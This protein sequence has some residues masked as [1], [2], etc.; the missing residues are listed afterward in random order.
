MKVAILTMFNGL[1]KTYSLANIVE[2]QL[3][4]L[5]NDNIEVKM[6]VTENFNDNDKYG[7]FLDERIEWVKIINSIDGKQFIWYDYS[8]PDSKLHDSF[9]KEAELISKDFEKAL[10]DVSVCIM[11]DILYQGWHYI[12]NVAIRKAQKNLVEVKFLA[13]AHSYPVNRPINPLPHMSCRYTPM[14]NTIFV[15]PSYS[16]L[17]ALAKQYDVPEGLCRVVYNSISPFENMTSATKKLHREVNL[18]DTDILIIYPARLTTGKKLENISALAGAITSVA[19][20]TVKIVYCDFRSADIDPEEYKSAIRFVGEGYGIDSE[21]IIFTSEHGF[22][23]GFPHESVMEL[24]SLSNLYVCPSMSE[25]FGLTVIEAASKGN[26][27]V[28]NKNVPALEEIG[29]TLKTYFMSWDAR[30][31]GYNIKATHKPNEATYYSVNAK[32]IVDLMNDDR[33][34]CA[35]TQAKKRFSQQW[36]YKNQ[37]EPLI[38][39]NL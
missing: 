7:I 29:N 4:M 15:Y 25:S 39:T 32:K 19:E 9:Y 6:L 30:Q 13:F 27:I 12:H 21:N 8:S 14:P 17:H 26:F 11:H 10:E 20:K 2:Q 28:V 35:K 38:K 16:G 37:L 34:I 23:N 33:A 18:I 36:I 24:F 22:E 1:S 3:E 5:L 31:C